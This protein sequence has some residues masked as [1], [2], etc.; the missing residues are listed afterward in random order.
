M[1]AGRPLGFL[2][3]W[4]LTGGEH[5]TKAQHMNKGHWAQHFSHEFRTICRM[6]LLEK[7]GG[8]RL[9]ACERE[10]EENEDLEPTTLNG[11]LR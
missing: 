1:I 8:E 3:A 2:S 11:L 6:A 10:P 5:T 4:L 7:E 9:A